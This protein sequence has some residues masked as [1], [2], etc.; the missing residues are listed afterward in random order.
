[1]PLTLEVSM[2]G[3]LDLRG[4]KE[5]LAQISS[6]EPEAVVAWAKEHPGSAW[7]KHIAENGERVLVEYVRSLIK[8]VVLVDKEQPAPKRIAVA[9]Q[10]VVAIGAPRESRLHR[11]VK[12][13]RESEVRTRLSEFFKG[14]APLRLAYADVAELQNLFAEAERLRKDFNIFS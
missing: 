1:M 4:L 11:N 9:V 7:A 8:V 14:F 13:V 5:E 12:P 10:P 3:Y 6:Q 2:S